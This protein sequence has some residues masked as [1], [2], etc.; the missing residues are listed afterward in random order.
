MRREID[1]GLRSLERREVSRASG[2]LLGARS[3]PVDTVMDEASVVR[4]LSN[5]PF[6]DSEGFQLVLLGRLLL[7]AEGR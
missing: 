1:H 3:P 2:I 7:A 6:R 4:F 5:C